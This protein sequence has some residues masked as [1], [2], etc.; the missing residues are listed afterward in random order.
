MYR[1][2][3]GGGRVC[4]NAVSAHNDIVAIATVE[5]AMEYTRARTLQPA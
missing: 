1:D 4:T 5:Q 3:R 2:E